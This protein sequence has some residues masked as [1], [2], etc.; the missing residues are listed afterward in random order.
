[1]P[2]DVRNVN[3][4]LAP[5]LTVDAVLLKGHEVLL[6]KRAREP[7]AGVWAIPGGFVEVGETV[8]DAA[9]RELMEETGLRGDIVDMLGVWSD[10][11]RDP[12]GHTVSVVFVC[13]VGGIIDIGAG[14]DAAEARWFDL[15]KLPELAFDHAEIMEAARRWI[16]AEGNFR[17][18]A[19]EDFGKCA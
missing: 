5:A 16:A 2:H 19:D 4:Y 8:E 14:D 7:F 11:T 12:R 10:P 9:R 1:M 6:V 18:L 15:D 17:K 3:G 13:K